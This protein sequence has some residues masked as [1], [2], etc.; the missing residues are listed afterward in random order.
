MP[1]LLEFVCLGCGNIEEVLTFDRDASVDSVAPPCCGKPMQ[2]SPSIGLVI[3]N[4]SRLTKRG[5]PVTSPGQDYLDVC[6]Q[7]NAYRD[8]YSG[9]ER[10]HVRTTRDTHNRDV[11]EGRKDKKIIVSG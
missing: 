6:K 7:D 2:W 10:A 4:P 9:T 11:R 3:A 5:T 8:K 1:R